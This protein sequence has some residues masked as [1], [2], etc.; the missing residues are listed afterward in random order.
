MLELE[1]LIGKTV[2]V[3]GLAA[4]TVAV[5]EISTL[6]HEVGN[7]TVEDG[8]LVS[9]TWL[10]SGQLPEV[11]GRLWHHIAVEAH[12]DLQETSHRGAELSMFPTKARY[13]CDVL[14]LPT[15]FVPWAMSK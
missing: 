8:S 3:D 2:A 13:H 15:S 5:G 9:E 11:L 1:V 7:D 4:S 10:T 12:G 14:T 6:D